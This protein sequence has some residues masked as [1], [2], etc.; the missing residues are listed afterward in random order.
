MYTY[1]NPSRVAGSLAGADR[2]QLSLSGRA[3]DKIQRRRDVSVCAVHRDRVLV[4]TTQGTGQLPTRVCP[5]MRVTSSALCK[6]LGFQVIPGPKGGGL[7]IAASHGFGSIVTL[8]LGDREE[9]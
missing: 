8:S 3:C 4:N 6:F 7:Q 2:T 1:S 5:D 9:S